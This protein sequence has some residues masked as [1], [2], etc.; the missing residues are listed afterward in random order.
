MSILHACMSRHHIRVVSTGARTGC[1]VLWNW[2]YS[3]LSSMCVLRADP[4]YLITEPS[5][6]TL[7]QLKLA[8]KSRQSSFSY[9]TRGTYLPFLC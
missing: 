8:F 4:A 1:L 3:A 2:S 7:E 6:H 5:L 9:G